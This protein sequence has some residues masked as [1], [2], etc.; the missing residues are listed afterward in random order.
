M[1]ATR[2]SLNSRL[3]MEPLEDRHRGRS[4]GG[5]QPTSSFHPSPRR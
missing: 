1:N 2:N 5:F 3:S 4:A